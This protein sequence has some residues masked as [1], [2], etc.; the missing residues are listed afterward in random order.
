M[1][2]EWEA[3]DDEEDEDYADNDMDDFEDDYDDDGDDDFEDDDEAELS[4]NG[5]VDPTAMVT[6]H[7]GGEVAPVP[8]AAPQAPAKNAAREDQVSP[9]FVDTAEGWA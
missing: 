5:D 6:L 7:P 1:P 9:W 8:A 3:E 4:V 2:P